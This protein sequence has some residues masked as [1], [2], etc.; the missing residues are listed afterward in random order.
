MVS[1]PEEKQQQKLSQ[2]KAQ[3]E[4]AAAKI[5]SEKYGIPYVDSSRLPI[6]TDALKIVPEADARAGKLAVI[7]KMGRKLQVIVEKPDFSETLKVLEGLDRK[8]FIA[9]LFLSSHRG[10]ERAWEL[11]KNIKETLGV[12]AGQIDITEAGLRQFAEKI[13]SIPDI[14]PLIENAVSQHITDL[15]EITI[16]GALKVDASDIHIEPQAEE[17]RVRY[18]L[19]GVLQDLAAIPHA[20][21]KFLVGRIKLISGLKMNVT[22]RAQDG[23]FTIKLPEYDIEVRV[24]ILPGPYGENIVMRILNP[25]SINL[26]LEDLGIQPEIAEEIK[27]QL[28]KPNGMI[29][30]TG[31]TGSGKTTALYTFLKTIHTPEI[32]I[33][34]L[35]DPIEYHLPGIEQT[36]VSAAK[37][38]SFALGLRSVLRQDPDVILVG[39]IRDLETAETAMH[40]ALTGHLVFSTL[41]TN[42]AA[43]TV[44][45]LIDIGV[46]PNIIAPSLNMAIA[47]RLLRKLCAACKKEDTLNAHEK[48]V[49]QKEF[50]SFPPNSKVQKPAID[51]SSAKTY[52]PVGCQQCNMTG[53]KGRTGIFE[54]IVIDDIFKEVIMK[55]P[56]E[57]DIKKTAYAQGQITMRQDAALRIIKGV[58]DISELERVLG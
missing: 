54:I 47:Q 4:E 48:D 10:L 2:I 55:S 7:Q 12:S 33:I 31:P 22:E 26:K 27:R 52:R 45:R 13:R 58:T 1:F 34:T 24:S 36:Q 44:P 40:A 35:E 6:D 28:K 50:S 5:L 29:L 56:S 46:K 19:D 30:T 21:F 9:H 11:Y 3:E 53:Y 51:L 42:D 17:V 14:T 23:R 39:E 18:R 57:L 41:H 25:K 8:N 38:Y 32:K 16:A 43:G 15:L 20:S 49:L 37:N